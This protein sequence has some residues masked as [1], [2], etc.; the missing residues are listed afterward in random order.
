LHEDRIDRKLEIISGSEAVNW[1]LRGG[2]HRI[3]R[4]FRSRNFRMRSPLNE[5]DELR[6]GRRDC[7]PEHLKD[8]WT[9]END[10]IVASKIDGIFNRMARPLGREQ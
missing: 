10:F 8:Q 6:L 2:A 4:S 1:E 7:L 5:G 9:P 3:E